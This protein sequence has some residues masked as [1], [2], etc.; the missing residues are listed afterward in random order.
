MSVPQSQS[1]YAADDS[2]SRPEVAIHLPNFSRDERLPTGFTGYLPT[3]TTLPRSLLRVVAGLLLLAAAPA[4]AADHTA[5]PA[6]NTLTDAEK[7]DGWRLLW[8]GKTA[9]GWR[10]ARSEKFPEKGWQM[11][12]GVL[13]VLPSGGAESANGGD[14]VTREKFKDFELTADFKI[15]PGANSGIKYYVDPDLNKG[16]G[17][18]IGLEYQI[19]D[20]ERHPDAK[21]GRDGNRTMASLYDLIPADKAKQTNPIGEWNTGRIVCKGHHVEHWF[22]GAKVLEYERGSKEFR[23]LVAISK[24][25]KWNDFGELPDGPILLQDHGD[26]VS[27]RNLKIRTLAT[28]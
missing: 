9:D 7:R 5:D 24:Y 23:D 12:D 18:A 22:N 3:M 10:S 8:D 11:K 6:S 4:F 14:I 1:R 19:L 27:F 26:E 20:D 2:P 21:L 15:T 13:T 16:A 17:S 28:P 25:A